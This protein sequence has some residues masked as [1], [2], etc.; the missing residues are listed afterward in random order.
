[1]DFVTQLSNAELLALA[2]NLRSG[3]L[4]P[5]FTEIALRTT[6]TTQNAAAAAA[7]LESLSQAGASVETMSLMLSAI[8]IDRESRTSV[9]D[10]VDLVT[11]GPEACGVTNRD[12][13]V[14]VRE[15]FANAQDS[16]VVVGYAVYRGH[17]VF[18][19]LADRM[20]EC[21]SLQVRMFLDIQRPA[22]DTSMTSEIVRR[23]AERF[24]T[25]Q[26]PADRPLPTVYYYPPSLDIDPVKRAALHAKC[27]VVDEQVSFVS[28]ANFTEAAQQRN[29]EVGLLV[30]SPLIAARLTR[31]FN[32]LVEEGTVV[33]LDLTR[34]TPRRV[35]RPDGVS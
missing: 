11:T 16:V 27:V 1:M 15:L 24:V 18:A 13:C 34:A 33:R 31:H 6:V 28:S 12:T 25:T 26:W 8:A 10:A 7:G 5:P 3:R 32:A 35:Q 2:E 4:R 29:I 20:N 22:T 23:F 21:P 17:R 14:V 19:A 30:R 9:D